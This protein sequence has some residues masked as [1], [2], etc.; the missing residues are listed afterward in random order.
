MGGKRSVSALDIISGVGKRWRIFVAVG[1]L[2]VLME[3]AGRNAPPVALMDFAAAFIGFVV[4]ADPCDLLR[5][6]ISLP[7][8]VMLAAAQAIA[9]AALQVPG[10]DWYFRG[11]LGVCVVLLV[12]VAA[13]KNQ[14]WCAHWRFLASSHTDAVTQAIRYDHDCEPAQLWQRTACREVRAMLHINKPQRMIPEDL[15]VSGYYETF[16]LGCYHYLGKAK[17]YA[18]ELKA[19]KREIA[20]E[21]A[22][23]DML[24]AE[25][26]ELLR[27]IELNDDAAK[28][29]LADYENMVR[30]RNEWRDACRAAQAEADA[31]RGQLPRDEK[32][33]RDAEIWRLHQEGMSYGQ[34]AAVMEIGKSTVGDVIKRRRAEEETL[35]EA[36]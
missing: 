12:T 27:Q 20:A 35:E 23:A 9:V 8:A 36:G 13:G 10:F 6:Y 16:L 5:P 18:E 26:K 31:L 19:A 25:N 14:L 29:R 32:S 28:N 11:C 34:I 3:L 33:E 21:R 4:V 7:A 1:L 15:V 17:Q 2:L 30:Q 24:R 22:A